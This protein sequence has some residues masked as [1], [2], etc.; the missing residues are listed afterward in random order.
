MVLK[1]S[2]AIDI[3]LDM[4]SCTR[5]SKFMYYLCC[6]IIVPSQNSNFL[7]RHVMIALKFNFKDVISIIFPLF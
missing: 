4:N 3:D 1:K 2:L 7:W 5:T 6:L